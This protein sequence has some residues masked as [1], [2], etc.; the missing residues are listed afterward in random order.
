MSD[1]TDLLHGIA[2]LAA[3]KRLVRVGYR[4]PGAQAAQ[5][6]LVEPYRLHRFASGPIVHA[7]QISPVPEGTSPWRDF[8]V[9]RIELARLWLRSRL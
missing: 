1:T 6:Y 5:D 3:Q 4:R 9:D 2:R 8:R 7:W